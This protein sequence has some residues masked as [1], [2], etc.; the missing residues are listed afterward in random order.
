VQIE[1]ELGE[2]PPEPGRRA[3]HDG[4]ARLGDLARAIEVEDAERLA[5]L[6]VLPRLEPELPRSAGAS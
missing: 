3:P 4:E 1:H 6:E 5:D 2:R